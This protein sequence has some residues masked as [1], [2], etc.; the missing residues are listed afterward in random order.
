MLGKINVMP[1]T[2]NIMNVESI[3]A[4]LR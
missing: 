2:K 1:I 3:D 4:W